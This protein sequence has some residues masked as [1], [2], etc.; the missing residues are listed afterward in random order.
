MARI[1]TLLDK[2]WN[3]QTSIEEE[4][5]LKD[6]F[7]GKQAIPS[8]LKAEASYFSALTEV[9]QAKLTKKASAKIAAAI[10]QEAK[11]TPTIPF[12]TRFLKPALKVAAVALLLIAIGLGIDT[13]KKNE[14]ALIQSYAITPTDPDQ[15]LEEINQAL[16]IISSSFAKAQAAV[17]E[18]I[19][20][21]PLTKQSE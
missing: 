6:F 4:K 8:H 15:A 9:N 18:E 3:A 14:Q 17:F 7:S 13:H 11:Q 21:E 2:Y 5:A 20:N 1:D 12:R 16:Q 10:K 19:N